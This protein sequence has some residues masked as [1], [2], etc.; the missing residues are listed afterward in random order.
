[1][2]TVRSSEWYESIKQQ[3]DSSTRS[4]LEPSVH[5]DQ[6]KGDALQVDDASSLADIASYTSRPD[7]RE[8][9]VE[10]V[11]PATLYN[12]TSSLPFTGTGGLS[13]SRPRPVGSID[14]SSRM[15]VDFAS[16]ILST[17][18][19]SQMEQNSSHHGWGHVNPYRQQL[20]RDNPPQSIEGIRSSPLFRDIHWDTLE[21]PGTDS[22][23]GSAMGLLKALEKETE[24][25]D[26]RKRSPGGDLD[27]V[28]DSQNGPPSFIDLLKASGEEERTFLQ[29]L[30]RAGYEQ[31][32]RQATNPSN[33]RETKQ[34]N[35]ERGRRQEL[36][37][38]DKPYKCEHEGCNK[39]TRR[40]CEM[41]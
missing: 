7:I 12:D 11:Q 2:S 41:R 38:I 15:S 16:S 32:T 40:Q 37:G 8:A 21:L 4:S 1:M 36:L 19:H 33:A 31:L 27:R 3:Q 30:V 26:S 23:K 39:R 29:N 25:V 5:E 34:R 24:N 6:Q 35:P 14:G 18:E 10:T 22:V 17:D 28:L 20:D 13:Y 9:D